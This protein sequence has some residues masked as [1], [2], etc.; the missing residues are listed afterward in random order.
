MKVP[1]FIVGVPRSGTTLLTDLLNRTGQIIFPP[2]THYF[3]G[4]WRKHQDIEN[5]PK[6]K[7]AELLD[8]TISQSAIKEFR[9]SDEEKEAIIST[10]LSSKV[11]HSNILDAIVSQYAKRYNIPN[12]GEKTPTHAYYIK[13]LLEA[14]PKAKIILITRD[15]RDVVLSL[16]KVP[17]YKGSLL[18][19][20][21]QWKEFLHVKK[22]VPSKQFF[23]IRYEDLITAP[24]EKMKELCQFIDIPYSADIFSDK[25]VDIH[26]FNVES[27]PWK[28]KNLGKIDPNNKYKWMQ[29][30]DAKSVAYMSSR[31]E[32]E[33]KEEGYTIKAKESRPNLTIKNLKEQISYIYSVHIKAN[34]EKITKRL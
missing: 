7:V 32:K 20:M 26:S 15:P 30:M 27:E 19:Y 5:Y 24:Q 21:K 31:L 6:E 16:Q 17:W 12:W 9:F 29:N 14:F 3:G 8:R 10:V 1:V 22:E 2:E 13:P 25:E 18:F 23:K 28:K 34:I 33:L 11:S 4:V